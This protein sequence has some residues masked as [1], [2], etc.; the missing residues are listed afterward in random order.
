MT[1]HVKK[2]EDESSCQKEDYSSCQIIK[3]ELILPIPV[4]SWDHCRLAR[5]KTEKQIYAYTCRMTIK[6]LHD[7]RVYLISE[8]KWERL[9]CRL[10][11]EIL[12]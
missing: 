6:I 10:A 5:N 12:S 1:L 7:F 2:K 9:I 8:R 3:L 4:P 11:P